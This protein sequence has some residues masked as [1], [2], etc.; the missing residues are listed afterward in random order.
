MIVD[1]KIAVVGSHGISDRGL[2]GNRN[3]E[4][5]VVLNDMERRTVASGYLGNQTAV[6]GSTVHRLRMHLWNRLLGL[7][8]GD[9]R[10]TSNMLAREVRLLLQ[11]TAKRNAALFH[12]VFPSLPHSSYRTLQQFNWAILKKR[13]LRPPEEQGALFLREV[14]GTVCAF[15]VQFLVDEDPEG[16]IGPFGTS[17]SKAQLE[18][19]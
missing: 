13:D 11:H 10:T 5:G 7:P 4:F 9:T 12:R 16:I 3:G 2:L 1:D 17:I 14:R 15:P 8:L 19:V 6:V 18:F